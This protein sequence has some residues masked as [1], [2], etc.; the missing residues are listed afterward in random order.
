MKTKIFVFLLVI[1]FCGYGCS[2]ENIQ[3][4][5]LSVSTPSA[6]DDITGVPPE[7][8]ELLWDNREEL[9]EELSS[10]EQDETQ[11][12]WLAEALK[13]RLCESEQQRL[14]YTKYI[15]AGGIAIM[16]NSE[17]TDQEFLIARDILL[18][19]TAK[20]PE[21][22]QLLS[23]ANGYRAILVALSAL[24][25]DVPE[26]TCK[27]ETSDISR[28]G[29]FFSISRIGVDPLF[30]EVGYPIEEADY[31][32]VLVHEFAHSIHYRLKTTS[33]RIKA[34]GDPTF[35]NRLEKAYQ[36][37]VEL[38][39]WKGRYAATN[40]KEY[41]AE[42]VRMWYYGIGVGREFKRHED[43]AARDPRL[44]ELLSEWFHEAPFS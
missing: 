26:F 29:F 24:V 33:S 19:M 13:H 37:A 20:H 7:I 8:Q 11:P 36:R 17:V 38:G 34:L 15:D 30:I 44:A 21:L 12:E 42:G 40:H 10:A 5:L 3:A 18:R 2:D 14:Y 28:G 39:T 41:W 25:L 4:T 16:G 9:V 32:N 27:G 22:R 31:W 43:F 6:V 23:P 1:C 35:D